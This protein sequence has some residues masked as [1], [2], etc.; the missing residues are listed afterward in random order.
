MKQSQKDKYLKLTMIL[1]GFIFVFSL[2]S[3]FVFCGLTTVENNKVQDI[4]SKKNEL[5]KEISRLSYVD[6]SLSSISYIEEKARSL[7]F[8][9]MSTRLVS[10][11]PKA[12]IQVA[13][14]SR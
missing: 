6:S 11:D 1:S 7:G 2:C 4:F 13:A 12:P 9:P 10:I 5:E 3:K 14:L 8:I